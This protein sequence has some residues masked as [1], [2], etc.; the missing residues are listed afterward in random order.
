[1]P[2]ATCRCYGFERTESVGTTENRN[3]G[4]VRL[5][6]VSLKAATLRAPSR[7]R[8]SANRRRKQPGTMPGLPAALSRWSGDP[9][10]SGSNQDPRGRGRV[11][12][13]PETQGQTPVPHTVGQLLAIPIS[14][15]AQLLAMLPAVMSK[16]IEGCTKLVALTVALDARQES[17]RRLLLMHDEPFNEL[18]QVLA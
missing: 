1:M 15:R 4:T 10:V 17:M 2:E 12:G 5:G 9:Y 7:A 8:R 16:Q 6:T 14:A 3:T 18:A 11:S 13:G